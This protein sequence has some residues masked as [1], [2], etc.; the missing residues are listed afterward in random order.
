MKDVLTFTHKACIGHLYVYR[1]K[2]GLIMPDGLNASCAQNTLFK[3][4]P[5]NGLNITMNNI[6]MLYKTV[7]L[8]KS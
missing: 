8:E 5:V 7:S 2:V 6:Y 4:W 1:R 3:S